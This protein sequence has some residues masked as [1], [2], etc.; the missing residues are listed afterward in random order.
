MLTSGPD[1]AVYAAAIKSAL[2]TPEKVSL[3]VEL[4]Y[5]FRS[6]S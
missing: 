6:S 3:E 1:A 5:L 2:E 4:L